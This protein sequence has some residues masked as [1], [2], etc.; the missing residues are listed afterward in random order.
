MDKSLWRAR[1]RG[2]PGRA[3]PLVER[4]PPERGLLGRHID[5]QRFRLGLEQRALTG[6][7]GLTCLLADCTRLGRVVAPDKIIEGRISAE[8]WRLHQR[9]DVDE[10]RRR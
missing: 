5:H 7:P 8:W 3:A 1:R 6:A 9:F 4:I 2:R 10:Y